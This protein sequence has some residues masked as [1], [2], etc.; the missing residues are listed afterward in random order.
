MTPQPLH[1]ARF[2][3]LRAESTSKKPTLAVLNLPLGMK[4]NASNELAAKERKEPKNHP[5]PSL[6]LARTRGEDAE[7]G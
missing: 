7:G 2:K 3:P 4:T 1:A 6:P 5:R